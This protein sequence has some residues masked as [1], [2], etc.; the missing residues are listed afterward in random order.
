VHGTNTII[1]S[2]GLA[3]TDKVLLLLDTTL[4]RQ[5]NSQRRFNAS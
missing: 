4:C 5:L 3:K 1:V 2:S